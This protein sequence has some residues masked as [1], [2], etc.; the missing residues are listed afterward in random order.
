M[1]QKSLTRQVGKAI[2]GRRKSANLT[3]AQVAEQLG[4]ENESVSRL[5]T[6]SKS[7]TLE[8]LE[9]FSQLFG[10]S[11]ASFFSKRQTMKMTFQI[12]LLILLSRLINLKNHVYLILLN[13][14]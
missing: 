4:I 2:A 3:Q 7:L 13:I 14:Q 11:V 5:E 9:Q 10:C 1:N 8:R 12:F 6:G